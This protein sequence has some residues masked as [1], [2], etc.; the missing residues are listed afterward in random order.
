MEQE[1]EFRGIEQA[2]CFD[3]DL[4]KLVE[5][6]ALPLTLKYGVLDVGPEHGSLLYGMEH[7]YKGQAPNFVGV[8]CRVPTTFNRE[9]EIDN[10]VAIAIKMRYDGSWTKQYLLLY[11]MWAAGNV[12]PYTEEEFCSKFS[13]YM[14]DA[15]DPKGLS[16]KLKSQVFDVI[17]L[18]QVV[19]FCPIDKLDGFL[20]AINQ[21]LS[22]DGVVYLRTY[23]NHSDKSWPNEFS[24]IRYVPHTLEEVVDALTKAG[25]QVPST[26][27]NGCT[28]FGSAERGAD[29]KVLRLTLRKKPTS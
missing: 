3:Y 29:C 7:Y 13:F 11:Q 27:E 8:D 26:P 20:G 5:S 17:L 15:W 1:K 14:V 4:N 18:S 16:N 6:G 12:I 10:D 9:N 28:L 2:P 21:L 24:T 19:H 25:F 23:V 22:K